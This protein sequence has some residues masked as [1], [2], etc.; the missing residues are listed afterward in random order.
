MTDWEVRVKTS[1]KAAGL[2]LV[3]AVGW[4]APAWSQA[5]FVDP[6]EIEG[7]GSM[8]VINSGSTITIPVRFTNSDEAR[9]AISNGFRFTGDGVTWGDI[10]GQWN[11]AYPWYWDHAIQLGCLPPDCYPYFDHGLF[12]DDY[13]YDRVGFAGLT[14]ALGTGLPADFDDIAYYITVEN[15][16]G[17][18]TLVMDSSWWEPAN[19]WLWSGVYEDVS[20]NGP[21]EFYVCCGPDPCPEGPYTTCW[22]QP[23]VLRALEND[24]VLNVSIHCEDIDEVVLESVLVLGK[25]RPYTEVRIEGDSIVTDCFIMQFLGMSG[26]RPIPPEG[27]WSTYTLECDK[28]NGEHVVLTGVYQLGMPCCQGDVNLDGEANIEDVT[29]MTD[30][31]FNGGPG[32]I[33]FGEPLDEFMDVDRN[34]RFDLLDISA[35]IQTIGM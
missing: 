11:D 7:L 8:G 27:V 23:T 28:T 17:T 32:C 9:V 21:F 22:P 35:L 4:Y 18:G 29:Y 13:F 10:T 19:F 15:I 30:Y 6:W 24:R 31:A 3:L 1:L 25:I 26:F 33:L 12:V 14:G 16:V 2:L 20:W 34:G 5:V